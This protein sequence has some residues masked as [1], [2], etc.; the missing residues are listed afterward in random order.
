MVDSL[1]GDERDRVDVDPL[2]KHNLVADIVILHL[3]LHFNVE[4]LQCFSG[5]NQSRIK[6]N[7]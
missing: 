1:V 7:T 4:Y 5:L 6:I 3:A 2:P